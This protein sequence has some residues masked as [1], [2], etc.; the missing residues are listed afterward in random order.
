LACES[1]RIDLASL[2]AQKINL[3]SGANFGSDADG[4]SKFFK[5]LCFRK[6]Q[7]GHKAH[8]IHTAGKR[9]KSL[10]LAYS[11][12]SRRQIPIPI[13]VEFA[14]VGAQTEKLTRNHVTFGKET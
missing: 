11:V 9:L 5:G 13:G 6:S 8:L 2:K 14:A 10:V 1:E 4:P 3:D 12:K 7:R